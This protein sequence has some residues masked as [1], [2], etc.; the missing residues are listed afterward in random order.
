MLKSTMPAKTLTP[1]PLGTINGFVKSFAT[2]NSGRKAGEKIEFNGTD[3]GLIKALLVNRIPVGT[4][5]LAYDSWPHIFQGDRYIKIPATHEFL[6]CMDT[7]KSLWQ[8]IG[9]AHNKQSADS[10]VLRENASRRASMKAGYKVAY[11]VK[12]VKVV[13]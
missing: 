6:V 9:F 10:F 5:F 11:P 4:E 1:K 7:K 3:T 12:S 2:I 13:K 8:S